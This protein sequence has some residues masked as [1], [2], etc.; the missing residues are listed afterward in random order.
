M[1]AAMA[2]PSNTLRF[3]VV[4]D[5]QKHALPVRLHIEADAGLA[6]KR[7]LMAPVQVG[8]V[9]SVAQALLLYQCSSMVSALSD[10][11]FPV[12]EFLNH[13]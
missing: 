7:A 10:G 3:T 2:L 8:P 13:Q 12:Q 5:I 6:E 9:R 1:A 11:F 4:S